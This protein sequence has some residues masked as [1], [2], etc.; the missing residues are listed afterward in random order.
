MSSENATELEFRS[1]S[2]NKFWRIVRRGSSYSITYGRIGSTGTSL[3]KR[4]PNPG[5]ARIQAERL[6]QEKLGKGYKRKNAPSSAER[7]LPKKRKAKSSSVNTRGWGEQRQIAVEDIITLAFTPD[8]GM[9]LTVSGDERTT[10]TAWT[11]DS[12]SAAWSSTIPGPVH[13]LAACLTVSPDGRHCASGFKTASVFELRQGGRP[14]HSLKGHTSRI[15]QA[16][17]SADGKFVA[18]ASHDQQV[19]IWATSSWKERNRI[20]HG[21]QVGGVIFDLKADRLFSAC[22]NYSGK[23]MP[24]GGLQRFTADGLNLAQ[25]VR[26]NR[27]EPTWGNLVLSPDGALLVASRGEGFT[28]EIWNT[29]T[30]KLVH[31]I[32]DPATSG[33]MALFT[34]DGRLLIAADHE[35]IGIWDTKRWKRLGSL[36][37]K[38]FVSLTRDEKFIAY[39][40]KSGVTVEDWPALRRRLKNA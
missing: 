18:T 24:F 29:R 25:Y 10:L 28:F 3:S 32:P 2:S 34:Q 31:A 5:A 7:S 11:P 39:R 33:V 27:P 6:I 38:A 4:F 1:G 35:R 36:E 9:L 26:P 15:S 20:K 30:E 12:E 17:F 14:A 16:S 13:R 40:T 37:G 22:T 21:H 23:G 19:R 8:G